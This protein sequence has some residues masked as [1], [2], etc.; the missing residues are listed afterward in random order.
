MT[1]LAPA[2]AKVPAAGSPRRRI[3]FIALTVPALIAVALL[4]R[5]LGAGTEYRTPMWAIWLHLATVVPAVPLGAWLLWRRRKG[6]LAHK[7][8]GRV[9]AAMM[10]VTA[11]D[12]FWIRTVTGTIGPIHIFSLIVLV[13]L[14][15]AVWMAR[16]SQI[17]R[18][19][20]TMRGLYI[21]LIAAGFFAMAP[22]R[23]LWSLVFG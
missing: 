6:D 11:I 10:L 17:D 1:V 23:T 15:R 12:S 2:A 18:H 22:G 8:G 16:T 19:V 21:G 13:Q 14:P 20:R 3:A 5:W 4:V 7:I 9:W